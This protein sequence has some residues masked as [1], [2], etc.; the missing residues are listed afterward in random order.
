MRWLIILIR[1]ERSIFSALNDWFLTPQGCRIASHFASELETVSTFLNG[2]RL[3]QL[4]SFGQNPWLS[5]LSYPQKWLVNP[6]LNSKAVT[7]LSS[8]S[9]LAIDRQAIDCVVAPFSLVI[10]CNTQTTINEIDRVLAPMGYVIFLGINPC[11][12]WG[13]ILRLMPSCWFVGSR[14][15]WCSSITVKRMLIN[16]GYAQCFLTNFYY[17]P[18]VKKEKLI[19]KLEFLNEMGKMMWP[20]PASFYCLIMQKCDQASLVSSL[21]VERDG[22][23]GVC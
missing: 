11:S 12:L 18:P 3:L 2:Q 16:R 22:L 1:D 10:S 5:V 19:H 6:V 20:Y 9:A 13:M 14:V 17:I 7:L 23:I 4:G 21:Q 15:N 8:I